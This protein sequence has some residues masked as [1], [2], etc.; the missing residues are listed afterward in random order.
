VGRFDNYLA[1]RARELEAPP[2]LTNEELAVVFLVS[3]GKPYREI[4]EKTS[5]SRRTR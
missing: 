2:P 1:E 3:H 5:M 4:A